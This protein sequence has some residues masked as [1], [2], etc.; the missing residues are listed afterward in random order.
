MDQRHQTLLLMNIRLLAFTA[1]ITGLLVTGLAAA[2]LVSAVSTEA[3]P[4]FRIERIHL[5]VAPHALDANIQPRYAI[6]SAAWIW[7]PGVRVDQKAAM[8]FVN[9]FELA[10]AREFVFHV[11]A[12]QRYELSL[13]DRLISF[14]PDRGDAAH[15]SFASYRVSVAPGRHRLS[16]LVAWIGD[17][18]P[19]AQFTHRPG[20][21]FAAEGELA[22]RL[23]TGTDGWRV[24]EVKGWSFVP[25]KLPWNIGSAQTLDGA[26]L[27]GPPAEWM[28]P[29]VVLPPLRGNPFG[30]MRNGWRLQPSRLPDQKRTTVLAGTPR[31]VL[32]GPGARGQ[33][34]AAADIERTQVNDEWARLARGQGA[35]TVP[36]KTEVSALLDLGDYFTAY[37]QLTLSGGKGSRVTVAWSEALYQVD[38]QGKPTEHKGHRGEVA[39]KCFTG[40][41]AGQSFPGYEDHFLNDGQAGREYRTWWWRAGRFVMLTVKTEDEPVTIDR[42]NLLETRYPLEDEGRFASSDEGIDALHGLMVRGMQ[43]CAHE[44][45]MDCPYYEQLMYVGDTRL[46]MLT[47]YL[48]T[49]DARLPRRGIGLFDWSRTAW[50]WEMVAEHYPGR[51]AQYSPT[52]SLIWVSLVRDFAWWRDDAAFVRERL[53]G[54]RGVLEHFRSLRG[55]SGLLEHLAGWPF[56]D[57]VPA[58]QTGNAPNGIKGISSI[59][60][61]FFVQALRHAAEVEDAYG[62]PA[63]AVRHRALAEELSRE[64]VRRF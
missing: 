24:R 56:V 3:N 26:A 44:T 57:W 27:F 2:E 6:E 59:N 13:D 12:D 35:V 37:P 54:V 63:M 48:T 53:R 38:A 25:G 11:S 10:D 41:V 30:V 4:P 58:W 45:Y 17:D 61:L 46:E 20:F 52:F 1:V 55:P 31:A 18:A 47:T 28:K 36:A 42:F 21:I 50:Q 22:S 62:D 15:W 34:I 29:G 40:L 7:H 51:G 9:D 49:S 16:A 19:G 39:K 5:S 33:P 32:T 64:I 23:N 14:G 60:N 8:R 43:M